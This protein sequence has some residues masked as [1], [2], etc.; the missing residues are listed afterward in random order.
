MTF[1]DLPAWSVP[2]WFFFWAP[3]LV[4]VLFFLTGRMARRLG[5]ARALEGDWDGYN[6]ADV[7]KLFELYGEKGRAAYRNTILPADA[8]FAVVYAVVGG[9]IVAGLMAR[10]L[11]VWAA[12]LC[13]LPWLLGGLADLVEGFSL[14]KLFDLYPEIKDG[15][16]ILA[17]NFT[18][19]KLV[20]FSIGIVGAIAAFVLAARPSLLIG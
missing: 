3:I 2:L 13:G 17:S 11:P 16:T 8:A 12:A 6:A 14:S 10:G 18:R 19:I 5:I 1:T 4:L 15:D 7:R 20:L 9:V